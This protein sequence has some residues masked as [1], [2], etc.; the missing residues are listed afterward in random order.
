MPTRVRLFNFTTVIAIVPRLMYSSNILT[1]LRPSVYILDLSAL[2]KVQRLFYLLTVIS[3]Y[4]LRQPYASNGLRPSTR[5]FHVSLIQRFWGTSYFGPS[6][7]R[8]F[9]LQHKAWQTPLKYQKIITLATNFT[10]N[11]SLIL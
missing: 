6:S 2:I 8:N 9:C 3:H 1:P 10:T 5:L 7:R 4:L 11:Y